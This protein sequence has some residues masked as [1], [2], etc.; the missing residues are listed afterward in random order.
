MKKIFIIAL[1]CSSLFSCRNKEKGTAEISIELKN[2][3]AQR[4]LLFYSDGKNP[5]TIADS[6]TYAGNNQPVKLKTSLS[7]EAYLEVSFENDSRAGRYFPIITSGEKI[8]IT[9]DYSQFSEAKINGSPGTTELF[10][11]FRN[12][13]DRMKAIN[14]FQAKLD[15]LHN[16]KASDAVMLENEKILMDMVNASLTEKL[17]FVRKTTHPVS[18]VMALTAA[19]RRD[20][21]PSL[22]NDVDALVSK[23]GNSNYVKNFH[24][25]Y[26][27]MTSSAAKEIS[28]PDPDGKMLTLSALK[29][30]YVLIDFWASWC[31]PCRAENPNV[32]AAYQKFKDKN[33][34]ILGVSLDKAKEP[35]LNAIKA[36]NLTWAQGSELKFWDCQA[37][38]D[39]GVQSIPANFLIDPSGNIIAQNLRGPELE[40]RLAQALK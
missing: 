6:V 37:A 23:F 12:L 5:A 1:V 8:S 2:I 11:Y 36:D 13:S 38:R 26:K 28:L 39:Y 14:S 22:K 31:G 40:A 18:A 29:G 7:E 33:F 34:T 32:V 24:E 21:F 9:G 3:P 10:T 30:K 19:T 17:N 25:I 15:S 35:W 16:N 4:I 20:E 27:Q